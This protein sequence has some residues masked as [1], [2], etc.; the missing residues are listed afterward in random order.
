MQ[1]KCYIVL[2]KVTVITLVWTLN[3]IFCCFLAFLYWYNF[4]FAE[5]AICMS[6]LLKKIFGILFV[7]FLF[8]IHLLLMDSLLSLVMPSAARYYNL[9]TVIILYLHLHWVV[10]CIWG[11]KVVIYLKITSRGTAV[12]AFYFDDRLLISRS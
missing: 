7:T 6:L 2:K 8:R 5:L 11:N 9:L 4:C 12:R 3:S 10:Y 1:E